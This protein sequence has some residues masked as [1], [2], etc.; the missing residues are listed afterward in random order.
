[1]E[2]RPVN[3]IMKTK[4]NNFTSEKNQR[5]ERLFA[6]MERLKGA[7]QISITSTQSCWP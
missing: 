1:M 3:F 5:I 2:R 7:L 6:D 4:T